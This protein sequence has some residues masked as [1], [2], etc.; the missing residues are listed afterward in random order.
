MIDP[1]QSKRKPSLVRTLIRIV[2][3]LLIALLAHFA[4]QWFKATL[5][6]QSEGSG[7]LMWTGFVLL[8]M[9][10]YALLIAVPFVPGIEIG[11]SVMMMQ[12]PESAPLVYLFTVLGL[13]LAFLVGRLMPY[14]YLYRIF[15]DLG[16]KRASS[17][18]EDLKPKTTQERID[19]LCDTLPAWIGPHLVRFRYLMLAV[20]LSI[21]GNML[22]GGGGGIC[23]VAGISRLFSIPATLFTI[24][25][26]VLPVPFLVYFFGIDL[27]NWVQDP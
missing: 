6:Q 14:G 18:I 26:A 4:L 8:V 21:P 5:G 16:L 11:L 17:L 9:I 22:I 15:A 3:L 10:V 12:G 19:I 7:A 25:L 1:D 24:A 27:L 2:M 20:S 23:L 13:V